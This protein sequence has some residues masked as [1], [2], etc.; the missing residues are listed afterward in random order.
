M[1]YQRSGLRNWFYTMLGPLNREEHRV[2]S[3]MTFLTA[4]GIQVSDDE[5]HL[6][7]PVTSE[8]RAEADEILKRNGVTKR[9]VVIHPTF[10]KR[11]PN[12]VWPDGHFAELVKEFT[13]RG[14]QVVMT[15]GADGQAVINR[16]Q[17]EAGLPVINLAGQ[18]KPLVL[19]AV[20]E[21]AEL[22]FGY[23]TGPMHVAAAMDTA[24]VTIF[25]E[26]SKYLEWHPWTRAPFKVLLP[27]KVSSGEGQPSLWQAATIMP[28][29]VMKAVD[30]VL[31]S[32]PRP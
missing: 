27:T 6:E 15:S 10:S 23:N 21:K 18:T 1:G 5:I 13:A 14:F 16:I 22:Y 9:F 24:I 25:E 11:P 32:V 12:E 29:E 4:L 7:L 19:A 3:F 8:H 2:R 31:A 20:L 30:E 17:S 28:A 26:P